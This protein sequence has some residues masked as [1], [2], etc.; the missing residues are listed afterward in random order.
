MT[1]SRFLPL[2]VI[3]CMAPPH[4][5]GTHAEANPRSAEELSE[6]QTTPVC[7]VEDGEL[8]MIT[9]AYHSARGDTLVAG[10]RFAD[11]HPA[12]T[13]PYAADAGWFQRSAEINVKGHLYTAYAQPRVIASNLLEPVGEF[14]GVPAFSEVGTGA[15]PEILYLPVRPGCVF[16]QY[17]RIGWSEPR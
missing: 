5:V 13:P 1:L 17:V 11:V 15:E 6:Q 14:E 2:A 7:V 4:E 12:V 8:R 16:Q 9:A 10:R 3:S